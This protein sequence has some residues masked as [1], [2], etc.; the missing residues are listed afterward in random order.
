MNK[1]PGADYFVNYMSRLYEVCVI[2]SPYTKIGNNLL[3]KFD[4]NKSIFAYRIYG[5]L[6]PR[7]KKGA[8]KGLERLNRPMEKLIF[9]DTSYNNVDAPENTLIIPEWDG[10]SQDTSLLDLI[11]FLTSKYIFFNFKIFIIF[12]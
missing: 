10:A 2:I 9:M 6:F 3:D 12:V 8:I 11:Q 1:R 4:P 7:N 5:A